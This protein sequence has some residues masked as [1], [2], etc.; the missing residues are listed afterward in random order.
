MPAGPAPSGRRPASRRSEA[1]H[2]AE[3]ADRDVQQVVGRVHG[4]GAEH[5]V[6][7]DQ[8]GD[9]DDRVDESEGG[10]A[11]ARR[12]PLRGSSSNKIPE[13]RCTTLCHPF[14]SK[15][16][17]PSPWSWSLAFPPA[18]GSPACDADVSKVASAKKPSAPASASRAPIA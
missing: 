15:P 6:A 16:R 12:A 14:T 13:T 9:R 8:A 7:V 4:Q 5:V 10:R 2:Q 1:R 17:K 11:E 3:Q 18:T